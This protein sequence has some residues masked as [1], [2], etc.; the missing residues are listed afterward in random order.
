MAQEKLREDREY[1]KESSE[2]TH[3]MFS[4]ALVAKGTMPDITSHSLDWHDI[5]LKARS[6]LTA[7]PQGCDESH[8]SRYIRKLT[9]LCNK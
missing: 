4:I 6:Q 5:P 9:G 7:C 1:F 3:Y 8:A 2:H